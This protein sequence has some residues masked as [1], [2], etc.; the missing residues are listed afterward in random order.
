MTRSPRPPGAILV[1]AVLL[2][3]SCTHV[4]RFVWIDS[5]VEPAR[6]TASGYVIAPGDMIYVRVWNQENMSGRVKVRDDGRISLP[7]VRDVEAARIEPAALAVRLEAKLKSFVVSPQVTVSVEEQGGFEVPV[8][9][10]VAKPGLYLMR[11][12]AGVVRALAAAGGLS[13]LA[14]RD[15][16]FVLRYGDSQ[17]GTPLRIRFTWAALTKVEGRAALFRLRA[18]DHVVVE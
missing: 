9:G 2:L 12:E 14:H 17:D 1:P 18:G 13:E 15:R 4:G 8:I 16:I 10:E 11:S 7:F 5:Y 6:P 3:C